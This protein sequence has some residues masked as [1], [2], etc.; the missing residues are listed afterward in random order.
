MILAIIIPPVDSTTGSPI[1]LFYV[2][3]HIRVPVTRVGI[4][5][6]PLYRFNGVYNDAIDSEMMKYDRISVLYCNGTSIRPFPEQV[7]SRGFG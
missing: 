3:A 4:R 2:H 5:L 6:V 1:F 7:V